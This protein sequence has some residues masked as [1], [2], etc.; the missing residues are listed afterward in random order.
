MI[1][2]KEEIAFMKTCLLHI[3][4]FKATSRDLKEYFVFHVVSGT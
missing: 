1:K 4:V 2:T 3:K